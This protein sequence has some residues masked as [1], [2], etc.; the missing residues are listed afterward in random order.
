M[1]RQSCIA[2]TKEKAAEAYYAH[3]HTH[4]YPLYGSP[5]LIPPG[6]SHIPLSHL[7][8]ETSEVN[9]RADDTFVVVRIHANRV[10]LQ[11]KRVLTVLHLLQLVLVQIRPTPN[12]GVDHM[13]KAFSPGNL[14][15]EGVHLSQKSIEAKS[16]LDDGSE[17]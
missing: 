7:N 1:N 10:G 17:A 9:A 3:P 4:T 8:G 5:A 13:G 11:V 12:P 2:I 6:I 14:R 15:R 16:Q